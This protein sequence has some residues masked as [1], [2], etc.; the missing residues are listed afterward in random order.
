[1]VL[2]ESSSNSALKREVT[3]RAGPEGNSM[4]PDCKLVLTESLSKRSLNR[5]SS[6]MTRTTGNLETDLPRP[7]QPTDLAH[8]QRLH[9]QLLGRVQALADIGKLQPNEIRENEYLRAFRLRLCKVE[10]ELAPKAD[11]PKLDWRQ[12]ALTM[13]DELERTHALVCQLEHQLKILQDRLQNAQTQAAEH[14]EEHRMALQQVASYEKENEKLK[15][16]APAAPKLSQSQTQFWRD[17]ATVR[18][19]SPT[20]APSTS[21]PQTAELP[22]SDR[23]QL[24]DAIRRYKKLME[25]ESQKAREA[26]AAHLA[27]EAEFQK[28]REAVGKTQAA[29]DL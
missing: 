23:R 7:G 9:A 6:R 27:V 8:I 2:Q 19:E 28:F 22:A 3:F 15:K 4:G 11:G 25:A 1:M 12:E 24:E 10:E 20:P 13:A 5:S 21:R 26:R 14:D 29:E 17:S 18:T 16:M